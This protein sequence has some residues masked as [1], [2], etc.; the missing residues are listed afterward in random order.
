MKYYGMVYDEAR[1][2]NVI[3]LVTHEGGR[4][5][6]QEPCGPTFSTPHEDDEALSYLSVMN[7]QIAR[8]MGLTPAGILERG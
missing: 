8:E 1:D 2:L 6:S 5:L 3:V 7:R 4:T